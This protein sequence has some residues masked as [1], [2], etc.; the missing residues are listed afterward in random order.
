MLLPWGGH[1][2]W[3]ASA[4]AK[5]GTPLQLLAQ[6]FSLLTCCVCAVGKEDETMGP[7]QALQALADLGAEVR[8][9]RLDHMKSLLEVFSSTL[10][11]CFFFRLQNPLLAFGDDWAVRKRHLGAACATLLTARALEHRYVTRHVAGFDTTLPP[12]SEALV[13]P[14]AWVI[15]SAAASAS[16]EKAWRDVGLVAACWAAAGDNVDTK[17]ML[18]GSCLAVVA[19]LVWG[20]TPGAMSLVQGGWVT[21]GRQVALALDVACRAAAAL[22]DG[23]ADTPQVMLGHLGRVAVAVVTAHACISERLDAEIA[24]MGSLLSLLPGA[25]GDGFAE[26]ALLARAHCVLVRTAGGRAAVKPVFP[27]AACNFGTLEARATGRGGPHPISGSLDLALVQGLSDYADVVTDFATSD[28]EH[29]PIKRS[30]QTMTAAAIDVLHVLLQ[31]AHIRGREEM[32]TITKCLKVGPP[33][34]G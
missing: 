21:D 25:L 17:P 2:S 11:G 10:P 34:R 32:L 5:A 9:E 13:A 31:P 8:H 3:S 14:V 15:P 6:A 24:P 19:G 28:K 7:D 26:C 18:L 30:L 20:P 29:L 4:G 22:K 27:L 16:A 1:D 33:C 12:V 23:T